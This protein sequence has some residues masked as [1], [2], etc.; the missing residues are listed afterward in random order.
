MKKTIFTILFF[1][2]V[3]SFSQE[4]FYFYAEFSDLNQII[5]VKSNNDG[6]KTVTTTN[7]S[8]NSILS[9]Y[10]LYK[11]ERLSLFTKDEHLKK[12]YSVECNNINLMVNLQNNYPN[13]FIKIE[14][15]DTPKELFV[16][17]D[18][19]ILPPFDGNI[20]EPRHLDLIKAKQAW[21]I[22]HGLPNVIIGINELGIYYFHEDLINKVV[23]TFA[24]T[25]NYHS[26]G[27]AGLSAGETNN[28]VGLSSIG[29]DCKL[30]QGNFNDLVL[31]GS[32]VINMSWG[33]GFIPYK[34]TNTGLMVNIPSQIDQNNFNDLSE[35]QN[36]V[37][38]AAAGNG[39]SGNV[40]AGLLTS[41]GLAIT[42]ENYSNVRHFP[43]SYKNV[44]S[45]STVGNWNQ[46]YTTAT[47][48]DNWINIHKI[49][50][51]PNKNYHG[52]TTL[53]TEPEIF[54]QHNDSVDI[55]VPAYRV[56]VIGVWSTNAYW[57]SHDQGGWSGTSFS[58]PIVSGTIGL[59]FSVNYCLKP[60]EVESI[61]KLTADNI[62]NLPENLE[63]HGRLGG[64]ALNAFKAVEMA[65]EMAKPIG[66]VTVNDR[67]LYRS[68]F[69]KL[70]TAPF[71]IKMTNNKVTDG[72]KVK[73][74]AR[75]NIEILSGDYNPSTGYVDLL[76]KRDLSLNCK[77]PSSKSASIS[78]TSMGL[79]SNVVK[80]YPNPNN[81]NFTILV[82]QKEVSNLNIEV[83]DIF[84]KSV[85]K[86]I[87]NNTNTEINTVNL[88]TGMYLV[89]LNSNEISEVLKLIKE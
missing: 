50:T 63:F 83:F 5:S 78:V 32:K 35:M 44:I 4:K 86:T 22:T 61:L 15:Y 18:Y 31:N 13:V 73:F 52:I 27:V 85:Y 59:M 69:Y 8:V 30:A 70:E 62:E 40:T 65:N 10:V 71:E 36:V 7:S 77:I 17:N 64:G 81:G 88:P 19:T 82:S 67:I 79:K 57:D 45:V 48:F 84:G 12:T 51:P 26:T 6:T 66:T 29:F 89:K 68:W 11:F 28:G 53:V 76:I 72:A 3:A 24:Y 39:V 47:A 25:D 56:P 9:N 2:S 87:T 34:D 42:A 16:P 33:S 1:I 75:A 60:K 20:Y 23:N 74:S 41:N 49:K 80:L 43:A 58:A 46:P 55:V 37:L 54:H 38:V 14:Q 21:D